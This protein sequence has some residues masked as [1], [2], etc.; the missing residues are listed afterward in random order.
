MTFVPASIRALVVVRD[1][2]YCHHLGKVRCKSPTGLSSFAFFR[3]VLW[4]LLTA[5]RLLF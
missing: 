1:C 2:D 4:Y 3:S 5:L